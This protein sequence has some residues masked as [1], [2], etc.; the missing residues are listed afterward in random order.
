M[1]T[2]QEKNAVLELVNLAMEINSEGKVSVDVDVT[3]VEVHMRVS[4]VPYV[5]DQG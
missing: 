5:K 2:Q 1:A 4:K 3:S